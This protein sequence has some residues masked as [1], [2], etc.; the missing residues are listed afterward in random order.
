[1]ALLYKQNEA[2][3][4]P[5]T[6]SHTITKYV[7]RPGILRTATMAGIAGIRLCTY[8]LIAHIVGVYSSGVFLLI[9]WLAYA[10]LPLLGIGIDPVARRRIA[11]LLSQEHTYGTAR[12]F[13]FL[14]HRQSYRVL[15][16][17]ALHIPLAYLLSFASHGVLPLRLLL[18]A[19]LASLPLL[20]NSIV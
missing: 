18:L 6:V 17:I 12:M 5:N 13:R 11:H 4:I 15:Y 2:H 19:G 14:L 16:Y 10:S 1:M 8:L 7:A 3:T 20:M 9:Q